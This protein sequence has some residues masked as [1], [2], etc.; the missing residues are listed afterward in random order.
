MRGTVRGISIVLILL[1]SVTLAAAS[2]A[3]ADFVGSETLTFENYEDGTPITTQYEP[4]GIIFSGATP[5]EP[6]FIASDESSLTNP[7]LSG[8]PRFF[9]PLHGEFVVP[10]TSTP[11]TVH[12]LAMDVGYINNPGSVT[13]TITTTTGSETLTA[14]EEGFDHLETEASN[15]TGFV[16]EAISYEEAGFEIDNVSFTP[17][18]PPAPPPAPEAPPS[19]PAAPAPPPPPPPPVDPC[20]PSHG[21]LAHELLA[22]IKCTAHETALEVECG[23]SVAGLVFLPLKSLKLVEAAKSVDVIKTLPAKAQPAAK[24]LYDLYHAKFSKDAPAGFRSGAEAVATVSKIKKAYQL[25]EL[26]PDLAKAVS[27]TDFSQI[28]L[29]LDDIA[30]LKPCVEAVAEGL[31]G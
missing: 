28:A 20:T 18:S 27:R 25:V 19:P 2:V 29:D 17:G 23:I 31:S 14:D 16:V 3:R 8:D 13:L 4:E 30:G 6:P 7:V 24:F 5:E 1:T 10:G 11:T 21:S 22:S 15:I 26:L 12:G 9:G